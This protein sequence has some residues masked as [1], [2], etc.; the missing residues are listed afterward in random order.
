MLNLKYG[1]HE[2]LVNIMLENLLNIYFIV[3]GIIFAIFHKKIGR[4]TAKTREKFMDFIPPKIK[5]SEKDIII[6]QYMFLVIGISFTIIGILELF[7]LI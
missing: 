7:N 1:P 6:T 2:L 3:G 5:Y 4:Y